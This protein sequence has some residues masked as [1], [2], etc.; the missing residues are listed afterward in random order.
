V[1]TMASIQVYFVARD[2]LASHFGTTGV[3][4]LNLAWTIEQVPETIVGTAIAVALLPSLASFIDLGKVADF[5]G[6]VNRA[7]R[8]MLAFCLPA[9]AILALTVRPLAQI[10]FGYDAVRLDL[11]QVCTWAFLIGLVGDTWLEVAVRAF[12][13][14]QNTRT[15]LI[16]AVCQAFAFVGVSFALEPFI[17]LAAIPLA[18]ALTFTLQAV[19]LLALLDRRFPGLLQVGGT[20]LRA[21]PSAITAGVV[22]FLGM[23]FL[24]LPSFIST[25]LALSLGFAACLPFIW[26]EV[27]LLFRL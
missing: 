13:A 7:L 20:A 8:I 12:Y 18:A 11:L 24:P 15:P 9:A 1:L 27:R 21:F 22:V 10:I 25:V 3:G 19:I 26:P 4:A 14:N 6:T 16:A 2:S 5:T 23:H 17:G